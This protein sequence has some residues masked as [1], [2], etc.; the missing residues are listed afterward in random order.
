MGGMGSPGVRPHLRGTSSISGETCPG[1]SPGMGMAGGPRHRLPLPR[2]HRRRDQSWISGGASAAWGRA[3][4]D[5]EPNSVGGVAGGMG[6]LGAW[7]ARVTII[8][9]AAAPWLALDTGTVPRPRHRAL[10]PAP[11]PLLPLPWAGFR[12]VPV[13][14]TG[15][16]TSGRPSQRWMSSAGPCGGAGAAAGEQ[17]QACRQRGWCHWH[18]YDVC[19][20]RTNGFFFPVKSVQT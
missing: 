6:G 9:R 3:G 20:A 10:A 4:L 11:P 13:V 19:S 14:G 5:P 12:E 8:F 2:L 7:P 18:V 15:A 17:E 1:P 16:G